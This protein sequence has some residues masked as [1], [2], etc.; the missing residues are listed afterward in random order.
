MITDLR[1]ADE[2]IMLL[3]QALQAI[4]DGDGDAQ[5]IARQVL[6]IAFLSSSEDAQE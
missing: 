5:V 3:R 6:A 4:A 1:H 2:E